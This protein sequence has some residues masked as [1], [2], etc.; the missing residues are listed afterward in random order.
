MTDLTASVRGKVVGPGFWFEKSMSM[1]I[2]Y[3]PATGWAPISERTDRMSA[4]KPSFDLQGSAVLK[5]TPVLSIKVSPWGVWDTIL[6]VS[7]W[8]AL[9]A[10]FSAS[11]S[12]PC[13]NSLALQVTAGMDLALTVR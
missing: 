10:E 7:P 4:R 3:T 11:S 12:S 2:K 5:A 13:K 9:S 8:L 1:G 6:K